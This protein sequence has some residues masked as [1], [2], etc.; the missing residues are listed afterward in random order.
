MST[1]T[2]RPPARRTVRR[3]A[4]RRRH[5]RSYHLSRWSTFGA[6]LG[7]PLGAWAYAVQPLHWVAPWMPWAILAAMASAGLVVVP[8]LVLWVLFFL[9]ALIIGGPFR[10]WRIKHRLKHDRGRCK[11]AV[12]TAGM[13][14]LIKRTDRGRCLYCG[15]SA[16]QLAALP[17]RV[18]LDGVITPRRLHVDHG[19]PWRAGGRT[20]P[21]NL[22]CLCDEHNEIKLNWWREKNGYVWYRPNCRNPERLAM[23]E[24]I[25]KTVLAKRNR[26]LRL[27]RMTWAMG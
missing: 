22:A 6:G 17:P 21:S 9:P 4:R 20:V 12:I 24:I 7:I 19:M 11:S 18:N 1:A 5:Y 14:R 13:D 16:A 27:L 2:R 25:T 8:L 23:A 26:P 3:P 10:Q 15:I